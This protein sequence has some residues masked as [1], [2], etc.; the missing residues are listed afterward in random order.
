MAALVDARTGEI[1]W[2]HAYD[3]ELTAA[4]TMTVEADVALNTACCPSG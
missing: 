1:D 3:R 2:S 4:G